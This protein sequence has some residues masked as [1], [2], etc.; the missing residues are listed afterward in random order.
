MGVA[1][2]GGPS[3][4]LTTDNGGNA[5][6]SP[7]GDKVV[8]QATDNAG[9]HQVFVINLDGSGRKQLTHGT[10]NDGQPTWSR[11]SG[12]IFWRSD[13]NGT[14]WAIYVMNADGSN[15]RKLIDSASPHQ[16]LWPWESLSTAP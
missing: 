6:Y 16:D 1:T 14:A 13:Q 8:Y 9:H 2:S 3:R 12:S 15:P 7:R 4:Q 10:G 11:D 5:E